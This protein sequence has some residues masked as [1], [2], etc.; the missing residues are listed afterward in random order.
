[1]AN[2]TISKLGAFM[3]VFNGSTWDRVR[4]AIVAKTSTFTGILNTI[5]LGRFRLTPETLSDG[6]VSALNTDSHGTLKTA[7][8]GS[9]GT[10]AKFPDAVAVAD[11]AAIPTTT[12]IASVLL[13]YNGSTLDMV[14]CGTSTAVSGSTGVPNFLPFAKYNATAPTLTDAQ[15]VVP[16]CDVN[17]LEKI[18]E[19]YAPA[20]EDNTN[21]VLAIAVKPLAV[22]T[23]CPTASDS[24]ALEASRVL[25]NA[26]G[27]LYKLTITNTGP[28]QPVQIFNS[29][30]VPANG[31]APTWMC[32]VPASGSVFIDWGE[33][34]R[35]FSNGI[36]VSNSSTFATKTI[37]AADCWFDGLVG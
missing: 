27:V 8:V 12:K 34:G 30:T 32:I 37:G 21:G 2:P 4:S 25:K 11:A 33:R 3:S 20:A 15:F 28:L 31:T 16:Q 7:L 23:Y 5:P 29:A 22:S 17:G 36:S 6:E 18:R 35:Y 24:T 19:G 14:R 10:T 26:A 13:G 9:D 1:V